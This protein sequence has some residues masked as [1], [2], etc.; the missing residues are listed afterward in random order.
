M[1]VRQRINES[2]DNPY[3]TNQ[4]KQNRETGVDPRAYTTWPIYENLQIIHPR[5]T[6]QK[7]GILTLRKELYKHSQCVL[8]WVRVV[9]VGG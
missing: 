8:C 2:K 5:W 6:V 1:F 9:G 3:N 7:M 4:N